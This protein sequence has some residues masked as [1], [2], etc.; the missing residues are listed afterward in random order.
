MI[1][2]EKASYPIK[3]MCELLELSRMGYYKWRTSRDRGPA[4]ARRR[5]AELDAKVAEFHAAS[6]GVYGAPRILADLHADGERVSRKAVAASLRRQGLAGIS[7]RRFIPVTTVVDLASPGTQRPG[8]H[9]VGGAGSLKTIAS[10]P[11]ASAH[12][13][14]RAITSGARK[15]GAASGISLG[16]QR[17][18]RHPFSGYSRVYQL[19]NLLS[20]ARHGRVVADDESG[21]FK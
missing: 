6:D 15:P 18:A 7:P 9:L 10:K 17:L 20:C 11:D 4:P 16:D 14:R 21:R 5:R 13:V 8:R 1:E 3:R 12:T 19:A 2:A